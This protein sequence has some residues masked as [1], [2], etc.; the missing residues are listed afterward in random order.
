VAQ[1]RNDNIYTLHHSFLTP[2]W[3]PNHDLDFVAVWLSELSENLKIGPADHLSKKL[4]K[5]AYCFPGNDYLLLH[6]YRLIEYL[7]Y[8]KW[9]RTI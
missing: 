3:E 9:A 1:S 2:E 4:K 5:E 8:A 6:N 7:F